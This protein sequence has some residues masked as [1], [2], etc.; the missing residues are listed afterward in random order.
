[1]K[2]YTIRFEDENGYLITKIVT[3]LQLQQI[4]KIL[5]VTIIK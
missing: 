3:K 2:T 4:I 1:M 5:N